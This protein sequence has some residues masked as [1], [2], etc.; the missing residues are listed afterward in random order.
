MGKMLPQGV[1]L[2][3]DLGIGTHVLK[4]AATTKI[5]KLTGRLLSVRSRFQNL[6]GTQFVELAAGAD[7]LRHHRFTRQG[8]VHKLDFTFGPGDPAAVMA[9]GLNFTTH[10]FLWQNLAATLTHK[11]YSLLC[12]R[13]GR[14]DQAPGKTPVD[15]YRSPRSQIMATITAFSTSRDNLRAAAIE[16]PDDTPQKIPSWAA[17]ARMVSSASF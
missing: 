1:F 8:P 4:A 2:E 13:P 15:R 12:C 5:G 9:Q 10:R 6:Q 3:P 11:G 17:S 7:H 14:P 16:P